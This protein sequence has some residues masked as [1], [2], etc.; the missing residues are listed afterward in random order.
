[1]Q[2]SEQKSDW[3]F[4]TLHYITPFLEDAGCQW[5]ADAS[6]DGWVFTVRGKALVDATD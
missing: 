1:M 6:K 4:K 5:E 3:V 2:K